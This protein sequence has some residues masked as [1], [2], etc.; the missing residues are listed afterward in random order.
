[1][2][3]PP[4]PILT[5][6]TTKL[7]PTWGYVFD[8][9]WLD[10]YESVVS[11]LWKFVWMNRLAGHAVVKHVAI[12]NVDPYAGIAISAREINTKYLAHAL[13]IRLQTV[14]ESIP[15]PIPGRGLQS[16]LRYC[17]R[18]TARGYHSVVHQF[19]NALL[20]PIH[21]TKLETQWRKCGA[22]SDYRIDAKLLDAPFRCAN[23]RQ[24]TAPC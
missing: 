6:D 23:C 9:R 19:G 16:V 14:R 11:I 21:R 20:C 3:A 1:M 18:C 17:K 10:P 2:I 13:R 4:F 12:H 8:S 24:P 22:T 15:D 7:A 5:F